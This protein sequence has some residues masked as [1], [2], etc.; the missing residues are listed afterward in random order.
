MEIQFA[1]R[2]GFFC[3]DLWEATHAKTKQRNDFR[4]YRSKITFIF[5]TTHKAVTHKVVYSPRSSFRIV[6]ACA[7]GHINIGKIFFFYR[8]HY[9]YM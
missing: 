2:K 1:K 4:E 7:G 3:L 8:H 5:L 9:Y 6:T